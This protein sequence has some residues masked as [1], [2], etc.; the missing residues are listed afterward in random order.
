[1]KTKQ[2][3]TNSKSNK[4]D[5]EGHLCVYGMQF[6]RLEYEVNSIIIYIYMIEVFCL[7]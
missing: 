5:I 1:M 3:N 4:R 2:I 7:T 6:T